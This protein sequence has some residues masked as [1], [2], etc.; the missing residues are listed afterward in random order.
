MAYGFE[1]FSDASY[2]CWDLGIEWG[3]AL[4]RRFGQ[5]KISAVEH[6][7]RPGLAL[8]GTTARSGM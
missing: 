2:A 7:G 1:T 5:P 3:E 6:P 4:G 8:C